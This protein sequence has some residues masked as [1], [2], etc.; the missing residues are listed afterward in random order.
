MDLLFD[1]HISFTITQP[2]SERALTVLFDV[3]CE[4]F[5][6]GLWFI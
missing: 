4:V 6:N 2:R 1:D 3:L 5:V